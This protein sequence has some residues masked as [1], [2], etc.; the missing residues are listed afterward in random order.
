MKFKLAAVGSMLL[1]LAV[2]AGP[3]SA[4]SIN[5]N[6]YTLAGSPAAPGMDVGSSLATFSQDG[7]SLFMQAATSSGCGVSAWCPGPGDL[8]VKNGGI[9]GEQGMGLTTDSSGENEISNPYG[10]YVN[11]T[12]VGHATDVTM[13]SVQPGETWAVW[14]SNNGFTWTE[15][16]SGTYTGPGYLVDFNS[17]VL[18]GYDQLIIADPYL[19]NQTGAS[20]DNNMLLTSITTVPEPGALA[21]FGAGLLGC[22]MFASRRRY[23]RQS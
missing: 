20:A 17:S 16:G 12:D 2:S 6:F 5:W 22:A 14:G 18:A 4:G 10:I 15:L 13:G 1:A 21:L 9:P 8:Y 11:L 3:A 7:M 23:A 19:Y